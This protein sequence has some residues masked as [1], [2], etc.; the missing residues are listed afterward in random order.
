MKKAL[1]IGLAGIVG[2]V[3][4]VVLG[5]WLAGFRDGAGK[6]SARVVI[7]RP[8]VQVWRY[9]SDDELVKKW[10]GGLAEIRQL[11]GDGGVGTRLQMAVV[12][13]G[14]RTDMVMEITAF[15]PHR[16]IGFHLRTLPGAPAGFTETGEY[17][18]EET[19]GQTRLTLS[20]ESRYSSRGLQLLEPLIAPMAKKKLEEDLGR[21]KQL[22]ESEPRAN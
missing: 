3:V 15:E 6:H 12:M 19:N 1:L 10:V 20:G 17:L 5:L 14:E 16:R 2:L 7:D 9:L 4:L 22:V 21:L 11:T 13:E 18:L 8:A